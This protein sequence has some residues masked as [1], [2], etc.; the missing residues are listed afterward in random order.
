MSTVNVPPV[1]TAR[2]GDRLD[3]RTH[4]VRVAKRDTPLR[5]WL[6]PSIETRSTVI[7]GRGLSSVIVHACVTGIEARRPGR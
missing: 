2:D 7:G 6:Y 3:R 4:R 5:A 1:G